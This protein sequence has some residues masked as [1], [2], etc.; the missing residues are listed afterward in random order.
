MG[1]REH[2]QAP[3]QN[4]NSKN[5]RS[6]ARPAG[7]KPANRR[8]KEGGGVEVH[9][10]NLWDLHRVRNPYQ[11]RELLPSGERHRQRA[12][13]LPALTNLSRLNNPSPLEVGAFFLPPSQNA[14]SVYFRSKRIRVGEGGQGDTKPRMQPASTT[15]GPRRRWWG[16]GEGCKGVILGLICVQNYFLDLRT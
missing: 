1:R 16:A 8:S 2:G 13:R 6:N 15:P 4:E 10:R 5:V 11:Y 14:C 9:R 12:N 3:D 7:Y